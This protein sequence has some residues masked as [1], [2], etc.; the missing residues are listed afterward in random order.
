[1]PVI[2][3]R[4]T[5]RH[6]GEPRWRPPGVAIVTLAIPTLPAAAVTVIVVAFTATLIATV[7]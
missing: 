5:P 2:V 6:V 3:H 4:R 7:R 1:V